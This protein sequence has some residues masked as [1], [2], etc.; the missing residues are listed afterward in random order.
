LSYGQFFSGETSG[1]VRH[2]GEDYARYE[3]DEHR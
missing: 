1:I 2:V 3:R